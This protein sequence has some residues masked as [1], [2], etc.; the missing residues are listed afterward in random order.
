MRY[1]CLR[2]LSLPR[3]CRSPS[4][5]LPSERL[6][7]GMSASSLFFLPFSPSLPLSFL[8][9]PL[10]S[11][12]AK[13]KA[14]AKAAAAK[15][16]KRRHCGGDVSQTFCRKREREREKSGQDTLSF[17]I[18]SLAPSLARMLSKPKRRQCSE[19]YL[20]EELHS[21]FIGR[22]FPLINDKTETQRTNE[23]PKRAVWV[24]LSSSHWQQVGFFGMRRAS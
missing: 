5:S 15:F 22:H 18:L 1:F 12:E 19:S 24:L 14:E 4:L 6:R 23:L 9:C 16:A 2:R 17:P 3:P 20:K 11:A 7:R 10:A 21:Y 8:R 13:V